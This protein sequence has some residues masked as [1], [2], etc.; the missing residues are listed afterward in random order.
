MDDMGHTINAG[1]STN[2]S[3]LSA[4]VD[5]CQRQRCLSTVSHP[6]AHTEVGLSGHLHM[7]PSDI[8]PEGWLLDM[9]AYRITKHCMA[10]HV[11]WVDID[12]RLLHGVHLAG[13]K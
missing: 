6:I 3:L 10:V 9:V 13:A 5:A 2:N 8:T 4:G 12:D 7:R 1:S 11:G